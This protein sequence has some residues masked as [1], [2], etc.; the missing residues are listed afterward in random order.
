MYDLLLE[1]ACCKVV[2]LL[3]TPLRS[4]MGNALSDVSRQIWNMYAQPGNMFLCFF[5]LPREYLECCF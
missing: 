2:Q 5:F 3:T 1:V 4:T